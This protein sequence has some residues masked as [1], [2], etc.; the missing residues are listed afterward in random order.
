MIQ[1]TRLYHTLIADLL[2]HACVLIQSR[3]EAKTNSPAQP[4]EE[5]TLAVPTDPV[6][7][8]ARKSAAGGLKQRDWKKH[9]SGFCGRVPVDELV[10][11]GYVVDLHDKVPAVDGHSQTCAVD[12]L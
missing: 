12:D 2:V 10:E 11:G 6:D 9:C 7:D 3:H 5:Y 8:K 1:H 4:P